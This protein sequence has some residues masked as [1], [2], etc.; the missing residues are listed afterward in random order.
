MQ[1]SRLWM[2][3]PAFA[4]ALAIAPASQDGATPSARQ[5]KSLVP[6][7][8]VMTQRIAPHLATLEK[9]QIERQVKKALSDQ[10]SRIAARDLDAALTKLIALDLDVD[11]RQGW[12]LVKRNLLKEFGADY[13][14]AEL[15]LLGEGFDLPAFGIYRQGAVRRDGEKTVIIEGFQSLHAKV[16]RHTRHVLASLREELEE[17]LTRDQARGMKDL[18]KAYAVQL[19][20]LFALEKPDRDY[21]DLLRQALS[22]P[23]TDRAMLASLVSMRRLARPSV[24]RVFGAETAAEK[25]EAE[26]QVRARVVR[27]LTDS[28]LLAELR[29]DHAA[30]LD[31][32]KAQRKRISDR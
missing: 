5:R 12:A 6:L 18:A 30:M 20:E 31:D 24:H 19:S 8:E 22:T 21:E 7:I 15:A 2:L 26:Q 23:S 25:I 10:I 17:E 4:L 27:E 32:P 28:E 1:T 16:V 14:E 13:T 9:S 3:V 11:S 29:R